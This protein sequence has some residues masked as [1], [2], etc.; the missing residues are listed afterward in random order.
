[1]VRENFP[2]EAVAVIAK[3]LE[4]NSDKHF[5]SKWRGINRE[6]HVDHALAHIEAFLAD[7][8]TE[9]HLAHALTRLCFA[10]A[11]RESNKP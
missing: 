8:I 7:D 2:W 5:P 4:D 9:D 6:Y 11:Q 3:V 10:V 1:M